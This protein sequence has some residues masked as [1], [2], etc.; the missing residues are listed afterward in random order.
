MA[1]CVH[2]VPREA[3]LGCKGT[4]WFTLVRASR[5]SNVQ[6]AKTYLERKFEEF[7]GADLDTLIRHGLQ[8]RC[9]TRSHAVQP[10]MSWGWGC[11]KCAEPSV[12]AGTVR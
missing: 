4:A 7:A 5:A 11:H 8:V 12:C 6:A 1:S 3:A 10:C 2:E 9:E